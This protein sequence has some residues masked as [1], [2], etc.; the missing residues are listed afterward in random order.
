MFQ[1]LEDLLVFISES[2][3]HMLFSYGRPADDILN[4]MYSMCVHSS[5][6]LIASVILFSANGFA[7][8]KASIDTYTES[9]AIRLGRFI[10]A[11]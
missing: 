6:S 11:G 2:L 1:A 7:Y 5:Y 4:S 10:N 9:P 8:F 3:Y